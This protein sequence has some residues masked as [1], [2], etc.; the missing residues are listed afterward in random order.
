MT[1]SASV[2]G[3]AAEGDANPA[4]RLSRSPVGAP[5]RRATAAEQVAARIVTLIEELHLRPGD[6]VPAEAEL[7]RR[8]EV[9]RLAVREAIRILAA[10]E[11]LVSS[12]GR[13]A[14]VTV[15]SGQ[16]FGQ[17]LEFR[18]R[19]DSLRFED[20]VDAR[21]AIEG[22][23]AR[24]AAQRVAAG[25]VT[26]HTAELRLAEMADA[27]ADPDRFIALDVAFHQDLAEL[28]G[29]GMLQLVLDSLGGVLLESR[30]SS[31]TGRSRRGDGH[32]ATIAAHRAVLDAIR[33]GDPAAA[34][35]AMD[36]HL[37]D[38]ERDLHAAKREER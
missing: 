4:P 5:A 27:V 1:Q 23:L 19:Q 20:L 35:A 7:S 30:R 10:R 25:H 15:P 13:P 2:D 8:F 6:V 21:R 24:R 9:N 3:A 16:V 12:Q 36:E 11:I 37:L 38:T 26:V 29:N 18:L 22:A 31:Y 33:R 34:G 14:R 28:G 17:M 32:S